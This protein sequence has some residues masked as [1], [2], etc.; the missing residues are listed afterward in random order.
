MQGCY[1]S[2]LCPEGSLMASVLVMCFL[3]SLVIL[4]TRAELEKISPGSSLVPNTSRNSWRS[5][6]G[7]FAF[8]FYQQGNEFA[9]GIWLVDKLNITVVWTA[10]RDDQPVP[11][12]STIEFTKHGLLLRTHQGAEKNITQLSKQPASASMLDSGNF[13]IYG[14]ESQV[15]WNS[16]DS[17][18]DTILGG[19]SIDSQLISSRS[20]SDHSSGQ[21]YLNVN[22]NGLAAYPVNHTGILEECYWKVIIRISDVSLVLNLGLSGALQLTG[23][24]TLQTIANS[25]YPA[26]SKTV[27]YRATLDP[28]GILRLYSHRFEISGNSNVTTEWSA[29]LKQCEVTGFCG[30]NSFCSSPGGIADCYCFP[31]FEYINPG[32]R[33]LGCYK[34]FNEEEGCERNEPEA[35]YNITGIENTMLG[36][37]PYALLPVNKEDC[38]ESCLSD[39]YCA[40]ALY[41][42]GTCGK[43]KLPLMFG[44]EDKNISATVFIKMISRNNN[45]VSTPHT[46]ENDEKVVS[47]SKKTLITI[48]TASLGFM[49]FMCLLIAISSFFVYKQRVSRY[50]KLR[51]NSNFGL[52]KEFSLQSFSYNELEQATNGFEEVLGRGRLGAV[53]KGAIS[54]GNKTVA[55]K[56]LESVGEEEE[57]IFRAEMAAVRRTHHRNLVRLL[58]FCMEG[59]R[60]L[61]IYEYMKLNKVVGEEEVHM[62]TLERMVKVGLLCIQDDPNLRPAMKNV[63]LMLEGTMDVPVPPIPSIVIT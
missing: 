2:N 22:Y 44:M 13:V 7:H 57:K 31:G 46:P 45:T 34:S 42:N 11:L 27:I 8:G 21:F 63:I 23:N 59:S 56:R 50:R 12:N 15:I 30:F 9:V 25:S 54:E 58:G 4:H 41:L 29:M 14:N 20:T 39:C 6:S 17:P 52:T 18:T 24:E 1:I 61:L 53:Y 48:L 28:D 37:Y 35:F 47:E 40:A 36:G 43:L 26:N 3:L 10:N 16:F 5:A 38:K 51:G 55:V 33:N 49:A 19:Q 60:K 32:V 62:K